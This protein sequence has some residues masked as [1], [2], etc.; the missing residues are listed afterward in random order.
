MGAIVGTTIVHQ[1]I[2]VFSKSHYNLN[3]D[4]QFLQAYLYTDNGAGGLQ[5]D[6]LWYNN[7]NEPPRSIYLR[8]FSKLID[9]SFLLNLYL[10]PSI[11]N[12]TCSNFQAEV[13]LTLFHRER[14]HA[15]MTM[16]P[17]T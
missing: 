13:T 17:T 2:G 5:E 10:D 6:S 15:N 7:P 4:S 12:I 8:D 1:L 14:I 9:D 3:T 11:P 16:V